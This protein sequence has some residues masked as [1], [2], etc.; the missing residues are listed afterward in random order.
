M[1][2]TKK[3]KK[4][5]RLPW[6]KKDFLTITSFLPWKT[7]IKARNNSYLPWKKIKK[8]T[9]V[10]RRRTIGWVLLPRATLYHRESGMAVL[11][12]NQ[13]HL[14]ISEPP[15]VSLLGTFVYAVP[16]AR[17]LDLMPVQGLFI[18]WRQFGAR[19]S[20]SN[21]EVNFCYHPLKIGLLS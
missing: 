11:V 21:M 17:S 16:D 6:K 8:G 13:V 9:V 3:C 2:E 1:E 5:I 12:E 7:T 19:I 10:R 18:L 4:N 14:P 15:A 20:A